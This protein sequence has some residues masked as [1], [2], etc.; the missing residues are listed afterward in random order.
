MTIEA[1]PRSRA[2]FIR[3][4]RRYAREQNRGRSE[5]TG[6]VPQNE[7]CDGQ[8]KEP[9]GRNTAASRDH[10]DRAAAAGL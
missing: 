6:Q 10:R 3:T 8:R 1:R 5:T 7:R 4:A 2:F 9:N